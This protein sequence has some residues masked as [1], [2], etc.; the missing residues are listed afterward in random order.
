MA[1]EPEWKDLSRELKVFAIWG[2]S[3]LIDSAFLALWVA[4]QSLGNN[5]LQQFSLDGIDQ[6]VLNVFQ[7]IFALSTLAP[8]I[9]YVYSDIAVMI[10][11]ARERIQIQRKNSKKRGKG[12]QQ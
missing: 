9:I 12:V 3:G 1:I 6:W 5:F 10:L 8:V 2:V 11:Q 4:I 7:I